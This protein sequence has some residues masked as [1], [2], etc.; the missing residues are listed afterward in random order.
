[1]EQKYRRNHGFRDERRANKPIE[2]KKYLKEIRARQ[3]P[4]GYQAEPR[5]ESSYSRDDPRN[6]KSRENPLLNQDTYRGSHNRNSIDKNQNGVREK[7]NNAAGTD[8]DYLWENGEVEG[9]DASD[10]DELKK[11]LGEYKAEP[12]TVDGISEANANADEME[13]VDNDD[14]KMNIREYGFCT[15]I[16][17]TEHDKIANDSLQEQNRPDEDNNLA[18]DSESRIMTTEV[19][20]D[21]E[22]R[23][24]R[25]HIRKLVEEAK[26]KKE[27]NPPTPAPVDPMAELKPEVSSCASNL[28]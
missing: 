22:D 23:E 15:G 24:R 17:V 8:D 19:Y 26:K 20:R 11:L 12:A 3:Q 13:Y 1:M 27:L 6:S 16:D 14:E 9:K 25:A 4:D 5:A 2:A 7:E 28:H 21:E 18:F 10:K